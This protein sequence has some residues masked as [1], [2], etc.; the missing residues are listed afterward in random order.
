MFEEITYTGA[1]FVMIIII[2]AAFIFGY[3]LGI[4]SGLVD[5]I[6]DHSKL[7]DYDRMKKENEHLQEALNIKKK[8]RR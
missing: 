3:V 6:N 2:L 4:N 5:I 7:M 8:R 1:L